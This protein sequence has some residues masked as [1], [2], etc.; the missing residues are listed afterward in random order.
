[1]QTNAA[2]Q[3][4]EVEIKG[5]ANGSTQKILTQEALHFITKLHELF[6]ESQK[7]LLLNRKQVQENFDK[8]ILPTFPPETKSI[9]ESEW[10]VTPIKK[11]IADRRVEITGPVDAKMIINALNSG[12]KVFM[13]DFEDS[14]SPTWQNI[15]EG[16]ENLYHANKKTLTYTDPKTQKHYSL[17]NETAVLFVRPRG[18]HLTEKNIFINGE[19][20][21]ASLVDFGLYFFHNAKMLVQ[22]GS[23]P[24]FYLPKL[25]HY[26]EANWWNSIFNFSQAYLGLPR[27][28]VKAT[29]LIE[30]ITA[31]FQL[32]EILYQ[33]KDH[34]AGL[35][36]GRWDY[37]FSF[38][39][40][41]KNLPGYIFPNRAEVTMEVPFI[42]AYAERVISVCHRR[43]I[44][45]MGGMAA[46]IPVKN[47]VRANETAIEKVRKDKLRE[48]TQGHDGTWVAHPGLVKTALD[49]FNAHM[50]TPNQI[51]KK[52][53]A[54]HIKPEN[55]IEMP[56][57]KITEEGIRLNASVGILY[58]AAWLAG[59]GAAAI[60]YLMEDAATAEISRMQ[61]WQ[62]V[63]AEIKFEGGRVLNGEA[64]E[65][66]AA[67]EVLKHKT[68]PEINP[69]WKEKLD[70]AASLFNKMVLSVEPDE[71]LTLEA[72]RHLT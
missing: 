29:V 21:S 65:I 35:N 3:I 69:V 37:I 16:Q 45:A 19:P 11:D 41:F 6:Y 58:L 10:T 39:K 44:H 14:C 5:R 42:K 62:W 18:L 47:D 60:N 72:Y 66:I 71:F 8:G 50:P 70:L 68:N 1:M 24:Y 20:A 51:D 63:K 59:N 12:C 28:T 40:K 53:D 67:E 9:R 25:E 43:G 64:Y 4:N 23:A 46:Q 13:A 61:L 15:I 26:H 17:N 22:Q 57:G 54:S 7:D 30:T 32:D 38:I 52:T 48:V 2:L 34:S 56:K 49:V 31:A 36:C 33:L 55:L 27:G